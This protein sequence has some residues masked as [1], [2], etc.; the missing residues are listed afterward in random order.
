MLRVKVIR[1]D[2]VHHIRAILEPVW[3]AALAEVQRDHQREIE[4][5]RERLAREVRCSE[6]NGALLEAAEIAAGIDG[7]HSLLDY[8]AWVKEERVLQ[9]QIKARLTAR[10]EA[11]EQREREAGADRDAEHVRAN[12][13]ADGYNRVLASHVR[14]EEAE[15]TESA[16]REAVAALAAW[17]HWYSVDSTEFNRETARA[18]GLSAIAA[19]RSRNRRRNT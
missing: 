12:A 2:Q 3:D 18:A 1:V 14:R 13:L 10:A 6:K 9:V 19:F 8:I 11:A 7:T 17:E 5:A 15:A 16:L 4:E